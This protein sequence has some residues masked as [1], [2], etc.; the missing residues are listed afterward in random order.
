MGDRVFCVS[1]KREIVLAIRKEFMAKI[2]IG[3]IYRKE[4]FILH[5]EEKFKRSL[6]VEGRFPFYF[7]FQM[8]KTFS[9]TQPNSLA[10][11]TYLPFPD[12]TNPK[13]PNLSNLPTPPLSNMHQPPGVR[14]LPQAQVVSIM[15]VIVNRAHEPLLR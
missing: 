12:D 5:C 15:G 14:S 4:K 11:L 9:S 1:R 2:I 7:C 13:L 10:T 3:T 6:C 8:Q